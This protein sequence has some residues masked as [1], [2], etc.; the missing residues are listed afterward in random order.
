MSKRLMYAH[1]KSLFRDTAQVVGTKLIW[2]APPD[3]ESYMSGKASSEESEES[4]ESGDQD[5]GESGSSAFRHFI[6]NTACINVFEASTS[7][8]RSSSEQ[9]SAFE[10]H[11]QPKAMQAVLQ[12]GDLLFMPPKFVDRRHIH[13]AKLKQRPRWWHSLKS[14]E[15]SFSVSI[16][17]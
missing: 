9:S 13:L 10:K 6:N 2:V 16:W 3:C 5:F 17:F 15:R 4:E 14:L 12:E 11:V 7:R 8:H 1:E